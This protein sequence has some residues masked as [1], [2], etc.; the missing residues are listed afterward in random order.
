MWCFL[1][2]L[3]IILLSSLLWG[4]ESQ[5]PAIR[6]EGVVNAATQRPASAGGAIAPGSLISVHGVRL[7][8]P[9]MATTVQLRFGRGR[10]AVLPVQSAEWGRIDAWIPGNIPPGP[11]TL[12]V[13]VNGEESDTAPLEIG[14]SAVGLFSRNREGWGDAASSGEGTIL[15]N[16]AGP[17]P[18]IFVGGKRARVLSSKV[19]QDHRLALKIDIPRDVPEGCHVPVYG[20]IA[21]AVS[22]VVTLALKRSEDQCRPAQR[23]VTAAVLLLNRTTRKELNSDDELV[24]EE[25]VALFAASSQAPDSVSLMVM[26]TPPGTCTTFSG[27]FDVRSSISDSMEVTLS[28]SLHG[29]L[30][31]PGPPI[32]LNDGRQQFRLSPVAP[33]GGYYRRTLSRAFA[34][35]LDKGLTMTGSGGK[36]V[37]PFSVRFIA[38]APFLWQRP[39]GWREIARTEDLELAWTPRDS[40]VVNVAVTS[41]SI[42]GASGKTYCRALEKEGRLR[43]PRDLLTHLPAGQGLLSLTVSRGSKEVTVPKGIERVIARAVFTQEAEV[44]IR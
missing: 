24:R 30:L 4:F 19:Q 8:S 22:N 26:D 27:R 41:T 15:A 29:E 33:G 10:H 3:G 34:S 36:D 1:G 32:A 6:R 2:M 16:T 23:P 7:A 13:F 44:M 5:R 18:E 35:G 14:N 28:N 20:R 42:S 31:D 17:V 39:I 43:I 25:A 37:G 38:Q 21:G 9:K 40:R 11:A 12:A